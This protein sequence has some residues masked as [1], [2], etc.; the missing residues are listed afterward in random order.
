MLAWARRAYEPSLALRDA[1]L[2]RG[3]GARARARSLSAGV[4]LPRLGSEFLPEL[5]E[6]ALYVTFTL[7]G[8]ISLTRG[9]QAHAAASRRCSQRTPEVTSAR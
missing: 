2:G 4:L 1:E 5:N 7:P 9:A 6:G 8:N 3:D